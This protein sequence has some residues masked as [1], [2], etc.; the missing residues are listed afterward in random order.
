MGFAFWASIFLLVSS[1]HS[2]VMVMGVS[3]PSVRVKRATAT[4]MPTTRAV[5]KMTLGVSLGGW[6][7]LPYAR[8]SDAFFSSNESFFQSPLRTWTSWAWWASLASADSVGHLVSRFWNETS[9]CVNASRIRLL[10]K[11]GDYF[12]HA[13]LGARRSERRRRGCG[14]SLCAEGGSEA[15]EAGAKHLFFDS[16]L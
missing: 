9:T 15:A 7:L 3:L 11:K 14:D 13:Y 10:K 1:C 5:P 6:V 8:K 2:L 4:L 16:N 12:V